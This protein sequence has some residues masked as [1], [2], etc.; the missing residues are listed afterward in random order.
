MGAVHSARRPL[1]DAAASKGRAWDAT[2]RG[3]GAFRCVIRALARYPLRIVPIIALAS[4][5]RAE[6]S[7][8]AGVVGEAAG[9]GALIN[10]RLAGFA[11]VGAA[12]P[13]KW[14]LWGR[15]DL[16]GG[17]Q[18]QAQGLFGARAHLSWRDPEIGRIAGSG[19]Y[20]QLTQGPTFRLYQYGF[21]AEAYFRIF[22]IGIG[23]FIQ[24]GNV[25]KRLTLTGHI[26]LYPLRTLKLSVGGDFV[27]GKDDTIRFGGEWQFAPKRLPALSVFVDTWLSQPDGR[28]VSYVFFGIRY[29]FGAPVKPLRDRDREDSQGIDLARN[30][31]LLREAQRHDPARRIFR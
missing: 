16:A 3:E 17:S 14:Q 9:T 7:L 25:R 10:D 15:L 11:I 18:A 24:H 26:H 19:A 12:V 23:G 31:I 1:A 30:F 29:R 13:F 5:C 8:P 2:G 22:T 20:A 6:S 21:D 27:S 4:F 28:V